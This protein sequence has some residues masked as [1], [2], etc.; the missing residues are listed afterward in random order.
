[1]ISV[2]INQGGIDVEAELESGVGVST[3]I[4]RFDRSGYFLYD[5]VISFPNWSDISSALQS[6]KNSL[7]GVLDSLFCAVD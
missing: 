5:I 6:I 4:G 3:L 7:L 2:A 1:L